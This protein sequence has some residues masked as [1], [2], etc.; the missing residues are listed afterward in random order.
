MA[1]AT[2]AIPPSALTLA[3]AGSEPAGQQIP[4]RITRAGA[5]R[6]PRRASR[7]RRSSTC[8]RG[9]GP[10]TQQVPGLAPSN[11]R[12]CPCRFHDG[13]SG[14]ADRHKRRALCLRTALTCA[15]SGSAARSRQAGHLVASPRRA[16]SAPRD[17]ALLRGGRTFN[18]GADGE[19][20][21]LLRATSAWMEGCQ[22]TGPGAK[23]SSH[24]GSTGS[25]LV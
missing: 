5:A 8:V 7:S 25:H 6:K 21:R 13:R 3:E 2:A 24:G 23:P 22:P 9:S 18:P 19:H 16:V 11:G 20:L 14:G 1:L 15:P 4:S 10:A 17:G 12:A